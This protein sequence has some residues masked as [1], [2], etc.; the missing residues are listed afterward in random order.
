M[1]WVLRF[2]DRVFRAVAEQFWYESARRPCESGCAPIFLIKSALRCGS[3]MGTARAD[4]RININ[5]SF[6]GIL[7]GQP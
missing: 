1:A 4:R 7:P 5:C 2:R 3:V 6:L